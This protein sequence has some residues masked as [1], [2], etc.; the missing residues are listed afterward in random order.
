MKN[1]VI[2]L[3]FFLTSLLSNGQWTGQTLSTNPM[4]VFFVDS[5][6]GYIGGEGLI[7]KTTNGGQNWSVVFTDTANSQKIY[8]INFPTSNT[9]YAISDSG[10]VFKTTDGGINWQYSNT[11]FT[12]RPYCID[13]SS[14]NHCVAILSDSSIIKTNDGGISWSLSYLCNDWIWDIDLVDN[15]IGYVVGLKTLK[16]TD[17]GDSWITLNNDINGF[18]DFISPDTGFALT[19]DTLR[20]TTDGGL[21]WSA[22]EIPVNSSY[23]PSRGL[24]AFDFNNIFV[25]CTTATVIT[26]L[27]T[28]DNGSSWHV[29]QSSDYLYAYK[30]FFTDPNH[31]CVIGTGNPY[32]VYCTSSADF[33]SSEGIQ[34]PWNI[35]DINIFPNPINETLIIDTKRKGIISIINLNGIIISK[36]KISEGY[37][38]INVSYLNKGIY[39]I[40]VENDNN[41]LMYKIIKE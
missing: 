18:V 41:V 29:N 6:I 20:I 21:S 28:N 7:Y 31:G 9:G 2:L 37:N 36:H 8:D 13:C 35:N 32:N 34:K 23:S 10:R 22:K 26:V 5:L 39:F 30:F 24:K 15:N 4:S 17:G 27:C 38:L 12:K 33:C 19:T 3:S 11:G 1:H 16:T 14:P 25:S 40:K